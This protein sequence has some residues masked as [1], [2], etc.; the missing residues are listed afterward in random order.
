MPYERSFKFKLRRVMRR[1]DTQEL[2][3]EAVVDLRSLAKAAYE[4]AKPTKGRNLEQSAQWA[5]MTAYL[6]QVIN[7]ITRQY[8]ERQVDKDLDELERLIAEVRKEAENAQEENAE[9][10][11][12]GSQ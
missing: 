8:D 11:E 9:K 7:S 3:E 2:R 1:L 12:P 5:R 10:E 4:R 6:Y